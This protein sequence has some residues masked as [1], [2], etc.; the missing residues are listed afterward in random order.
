MRKVTKLF[1]TKALSVDDENKTITFKISD[2]QPDRMGECVDQDS[3]Q[4]DNYNNNPI[5]LWGHDPTEPENVLGTTQEFV[6]GLKDKSGKYSTAKI[7]FD[8]DIN[9]K[10][11]LVYNQAKRGTLRTTSIGF[12]P[13]TEEMDADMPVLKDNELFEISVVPIPAN[14]RAIALEMKSGLIS[15]KD[16]SWVLESMQK[17]TA[18][19]EE[20]MKEEET[21]DKDDTTMN[22]QVTKQFG[23][24]LDAIT[25]LAES[26]AATNERLDQLA[27]QLQEK[28]LV[29]KLLPLCP[30]D[31]KWDGGAAREAVKAWASDSDGNVDFA[32]YGKAFFAKTADGTKEGDYK[33]PFATIEGGKLCAVWNGVKAAYEAVKGARGGV[34]GI[35]EDA[36]LSKIK[37]Y[38]K[39]FGKDMPEKAMDAEDLH[40][41]DADT[42]DAAAG[43]TAT[44]T[45]DD[46]ATATNDSTTTDT[47][48][49]DD[50]TSTDDTQTD[51]DKTTTDDVA[52]DGDDDQ[53]GAQDGEDDPDIDLDAEL[54]PEL[55]AQLDGAQ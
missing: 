46:T 17:E 37:A 13:H 47:A 43:E 22:E 54:T 23:T 3:W 35:D 53:S 10:A 48:T 7:K 55:Q 2:D 14:P 40:T 20:Q 9:P 38:Y 12:M 11:S 5:V 1:Q 21:N 34:E 44:T 50:D 27:E 42:T 41:K 36:V 24:M 49:A 39:K 26:Q 15:R 8:T 25:K 31:E 32:K 30:E 16:A 52:K 4:L 28:E 45:D 29:T 51:D 6:G 18:Y 33:L 19:I